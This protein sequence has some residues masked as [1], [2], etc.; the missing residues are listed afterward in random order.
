VTDTPTATATVGPP[1]VGDCGEDGTVTVDEILTMVNIAL[2]NVELSTCEDGDGNGD[3]QITIDEIL[4][5]VN[6]ALT[7][8]PGPRVCGGIDGL[9]CGSGEVCDLRDPT[10]A[11][12]NLLGVCVSRPEICPDV[13]D[14]VCGCDGVTYANECLR[15]NVGAKLAHAGACP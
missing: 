8:C 12:L 2:G 9:P 3:G 14:P 15:L 11:V 7:A 4:T 1:C 13:F 6:H 5:A 10:C